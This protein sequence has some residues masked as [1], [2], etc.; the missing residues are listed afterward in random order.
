MDNV[1]MLSTILGYIADFKDYRSVCLV[2]KLFKETL[3][4]SMEIFEYNPPIKSLGVFHD[5]SRKTGRI[6]V[7]E[8]AMKDLPKLRIIKTG[9]D[10]MICPERVFEAFTKKFNSYSIRIIQDENQWVQDHVPYNFLTTIFS[11]ISQHV[12]D[13]PVVYIETPGKFRFSYENG[14]MF[15]QGLDSLIFSVDKSKSRG[16]MSL[17]IAKGVSTRN[18]IIEQL[19]GISKISNFIKVMSS[20]VLSFFFSG[21]IRI[22]D[23]FPKAE[24]MVKSVDSEFHKEVYLFKIIIDI[25][26]LAPYTSIVYNSDLYLRHIIDAGKLE[27]INSQKIIIATV[28]STIGLITKMRHSWNDDLKLNRTMNIFFVKDPD[29]LD[30]KSSSIGSLNVERDHEGLCKE[31]FRMKVGKRRSDY[32]DIIRIFST[33]SP[34]LDEKIVKSCEISYGSRR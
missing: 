6:T 9:E 30:F 34:V 1:D 23:C 8:K 13:N 11:T 28:G 18:H 19:K 17:L 5:P 4:N 14:E 15:M 32:H 2:S 31:I 10:V 12:Q 29:R 27:D 26:Y 25:S 3:R 22:K 33:L 24:W 21:S 20:D 16:E 7:T